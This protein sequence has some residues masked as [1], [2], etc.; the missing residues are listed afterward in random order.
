VKEEIGT[1]KD[2]EKSFQSWLKL[3]IFL[4]DNAYL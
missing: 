1:I 2:F 3:K 4:L